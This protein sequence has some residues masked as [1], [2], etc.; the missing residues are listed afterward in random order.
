M[1]AAVWASVA[2]G[3]PLGWTVDVTAGAPQH[4]PVQA[5]LADRCRQ[6]PPTGAATH[7]GL[8]VEGLAAAA[9]IYGKKSGRS[10]WGHASVRVLLCVGG[11]PLDVEYEAYRFGPEL[12]TV[13]A[14][15]HPGRAWL[16]DDPSRFDGDL[17]LLRNQGTVDRAFYA[18][19]LA[20]N[21]ELYEL[22]LD[23][24]PT[25]V[26]GLFFALEAALSEQED[27]FTA[28][29]HPEYRYQPLGHNCTWPL[30]FGASACRSPMPF[31]HLRALEEQ[32]A[33]RVILPSGHLLARPE[34]VHGAV[35]PR[36]HPVLRRPRSA[37]SIAAAPA[38]LE[39]VVVSWLLARERVVADTP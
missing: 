24:T 16:W 10:T 9:V 34:V 35:I 26:E 36:P 11:W 21:R 32:A 13:M 5:S 20:R 37:G 39:P 33:L 2:L 17:T 23:W 19:S 27:A 7:H 31:A 30:K 15:D 3:A 18:T 4:R 28:G 1:S 12:V 6:D 25:Q 29:E 38:G 14:V 8:P 22:W